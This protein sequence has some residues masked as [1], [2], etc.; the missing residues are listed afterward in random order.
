MIISEHIFTLCDTSSRFTIVFFNFLILYRLKDNEFIFLQ[1]KHEF[2]VELPNHF[3]TCIYCIKIATCTFQ[4]LW[5]LKMSFS[6]IQGPKNTSFDLYKS[7]FYQI[8]KVKNK[9][10]AY[11]G[12]IKSFRFRVVLCACL[13]I[14]AAFMPPV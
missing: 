7:C 6:S 4:I 8:N 13:Y 12:K 1:E 10:L 14:I 5:V 11:A 3:N 9:A 2:K